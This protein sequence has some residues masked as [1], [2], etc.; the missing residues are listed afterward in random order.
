MAQ[1]GQGCCLEAVTEDM[2]SGLGHKGPSKECS[3]SREQLL[4]RHRGWGGASIEAGPVESFCLTGQAEERGL[5]RR[6]GGP[7]GLKKG[8][9]DGQSQAS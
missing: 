1:A 7:W 8:W 5:P 9:L 3:M 6:Q 4:Q 2:A